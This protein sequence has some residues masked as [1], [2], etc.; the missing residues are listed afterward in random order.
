MNVLIV[1]DEAQI[2]RWFESL[3]ARTGLP[4][5]VI[6]S[7]GNGAE[8]L[9]LCREHA[10]DLVITDIRMP[11]MDG[12]ELIRCLAR[13]QPAVRTLILSSYDEFK[14]ASEALKLGA[15]DYM[16]K[17][18]ITIEALREAV[19]KAHGRMVAERR[20]TEE[21]LTLKSRINENQY[22]LRADYFKN[23]L[24]GDQAAVRIF[25][26]KMELFRTTLGDKHIMLMAV[27]L[28]EPAGAG[29]A[30]I[31]DPAL[32]EQAILNIADETIRC[33]TK[34]GCGFLYGENTF[35][36]LFNAEGFGGKS[37]REQA[38]RA[39][40]RLSDNLRDYLNVS[41]SVGISE[42]H[43]DLSALPRQLKKALE[44]LKQRRFHGKRNVA[45]AS[46]EMPVLTAEIRKSAHAVIGEIAGDMET[47]SYERAMQALNA[48]L[49][50]DARLKE[51]P[52]GHFKALCLELVFAVLHNVRKV[53]RQADSLDRYRS[54]SLHEQ[55]NELKTYEEAKDWLLRM[56]AGL[57]EE[58][59]RLR[60]PYSEPIRGA[61]RFLE[62][63]Y[64]EEI[65]LQQAADYVH[66]NKTYLSELFK[67][68]T[69]VSFNDKLTQIRID[70]AKALIA[71][72]EIRMGALA[73]R[74][75][76]P[77]ASY[78]TKVFKKAT[79]MTPLEY[80]QRK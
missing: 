57:L 49:S 63:R 61:L 4:I 65:S 71:A 32:L 6:A 39:A 28:D 30:K 80:K 51:M 64:A 50:D 70:Q 34:T 25:R 43:Y 40:Y 76:Y 36:V 47:S 22:A 74:V 8:A 77:N 35:V 24:R 66:L 26:E 2:R 54:E 20:R 45:W 68:E 72:G 29:Q 52:E 16:L 41:A 67:K 9:A 33:E 13:E 1:D 79:G 58:A 10:V 42:P 18:E 3:L 69:G 17:A 46:D 14:Y 27:G 48:F 60:P 56:V 23:L 7:C 78:F 37:V 31:G 59:A 75:G 53:E 55:L 21:V 15:D 38:I 5:E 44:A 62:T 12:L 19:E 11:I 73:E